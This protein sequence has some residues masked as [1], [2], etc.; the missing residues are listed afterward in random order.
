M[1]HVRGLMHACSHDAS[2]IQEGLK[3]EVQGFLTHFLSDPYRSV[4]VIRNQEHL[5]ELLKDFVE[6][7][8]EGEFDE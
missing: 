8:E 1:G 3:P 4:D 5:D 2:F 7:V 6:V